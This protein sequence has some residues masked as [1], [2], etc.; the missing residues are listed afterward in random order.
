MSKQGVYLRGKKWWI[1]YSVPGQGQKREPGGATKSEA[2]SKLERRKAEILTG[3][4]IG[5]GQEKVTVGELLADMLREYRAR[6][7]R[8]ISGV[9]SAVK[10]QLALLEHVR[11][12]SLTTD[13]ISDWIA[14]LRSR[15]YKDGTI[16]KARDL[17][18]IAYGMG[19]RR[20]PP[21]VTRIPHFPPVPVNDARQGFL[22]ATAFTRLLAALPQGMTASGNLRTLITLAYASGARRGELLKLRW[23]QVDWRARAITL[24]RQQTKNGHARVLPLDLVPELYPMLR[25]DWEATQ[26]NHPDCPWIFHRQGRRIVSFL[27]AWKRATSAA[28]LPGLLFHDLRRTAV[29]NMVRAGI[30]TAVARSISGHRT[31]EVFERYNIVDTRDV[32]DAAVKVQSYIRAERQSG[33]VSTNLAQTV[34]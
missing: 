14:E 4:Y 20:T 32:A 1:R 6:G 24:G 27:Q 26:A 2:V 13:Q 7:L 31:M 34:N 28:G 12:A 19:A 30:P 11:A 9:E 15:G 25:A 18:V 22:D 17:L 5:P 29:R 21:K 33:Q 16:A 3:N 8:S 23:E 10:H